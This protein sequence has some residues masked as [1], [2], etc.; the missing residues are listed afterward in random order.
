MG[1]KSP[2]KSQSP[3]NRGI[4]QTTEGAAAFDLFA[5]QSPN[6]R[7]IL[8][9]RRMQEIEVFLSLNPL[10]IGASFKRLI[11]CRKTSRMSQSPNNRG[12]LQTENEK[13]GN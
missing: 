2:M 3:N 7:G 6:N 1:F 11:R 5:S 4:L 9:T 8:Q 10:I 12:I 13:Q